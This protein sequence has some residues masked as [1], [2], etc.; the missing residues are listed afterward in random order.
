MFLVSARLSS[1]LPSFFVFF[2]YRFIYI[3]ILFTFIHRSYA[4]WKN[5]RNISLFSSLVFLLILFRTVFSVRAAFEPFYNRSGD[6]WYFS[7]G[8]F[9]II[10][11]KLILNYRRK[12]FPFHTF[13]RSFIRSLGT[14]KSQEIPFM[15]PYRFVKYF[16]NRVIFTRQKIL[17]DLENS[18]WF[19][20]RIFLLDFRSFADNVYV[21]IHRVV[22][23]SI[24]FLFFT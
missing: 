24:L 22:A 5:S 3:L 2:Y 12:S 8:L 14:I 23:L 20:P 13:V 17:P 10:D 4:H 21:N 16:S 6:L 19:A 11:F 9:H 18:H 15:C 7:D 1:S